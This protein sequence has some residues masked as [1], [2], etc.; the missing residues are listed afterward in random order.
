MHWFDYAGQLV[1]WRGVFVPDKQSAHCRAVWLFEGIWIF[2]NTATF[3]A[4]FPKFDL[5]GC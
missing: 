4:K 2:A 5:L 3:S 1:G